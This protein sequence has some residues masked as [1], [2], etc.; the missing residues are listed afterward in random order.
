MAVAAVR[1]V[2][3]TGLDMAT[4]QILGAEYAIAV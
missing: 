4:R 2:A 1:P 3:P